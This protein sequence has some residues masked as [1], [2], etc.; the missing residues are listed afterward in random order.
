MEQTIVSVETASTT[1]SVTVSRTSPSVRCFSAA[2]ETR[3]T[4]SEVAA[5]TCQSERVVRD[6]NIRCG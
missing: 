5:A 4:F 6:R 2:R 3:I 1:T